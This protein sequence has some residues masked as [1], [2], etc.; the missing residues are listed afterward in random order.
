MKS[1]SPRRK[2]PT[3]AIMTHINLDVAE[4]SVRRFVLALAHDPAGSVLEMNGRPVAW[5][6][7]A[8]ATPAD[9]DEPWT[10][11]KNQRRCD[12]I[13]R[14]YAGQLGPDEAVELAR[15]QDEM[16][17]HRQRVAPLPLEDARRLHQELLSRATS[18]P[19][20]DPGVH[21]SITRQASRGTAA[22]CLPSDTGSRRSGPRRGGR[23][24]VFDAP[25]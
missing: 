10:E 3:G 21:R 14:K 18:K 24:G 8:G 16:L 1:F 19:S 6:V 13:D 20:A 4:E 23:G 9:G 17:R 11:A 15:L 25:G 12:L 5:V 7:P 2:E 22:M